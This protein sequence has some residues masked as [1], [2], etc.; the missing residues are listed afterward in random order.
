[1]TRKTSKKLRA[2]EKLLSDFYART[3]SITSVFS[4]SRKNLNKNVL[5]RLLAF[6]QSLWPRFK[7][8]ARPTKAKYYSEKMDEYD[9]E[10]SITYLRCTL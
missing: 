9:N 3:A 5:P 8:A 1:M 4:D 7:W 2:A 6:V 10:I